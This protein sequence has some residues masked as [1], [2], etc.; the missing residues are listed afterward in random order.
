MVPRERECQVIRLP[1]W[2][3]LCQ[4]WTL[5]EEMLHS[6][7]PNPQR[8]WGADSI[9]TRFCSKCIPFHDQVSSRLLPGELRTRGC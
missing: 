6:H 5:K 8:V 4:I 2:V 3:I 9:S 1:E 7:P